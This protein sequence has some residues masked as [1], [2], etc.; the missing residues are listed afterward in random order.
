MFLVKNYFKY[1]LF[2]FLNGGGVIY[3][4]F[5]IIFMGFE[6]YSIR[7]NWL[8]GVYVRNSF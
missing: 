4:I 7:G 1:F 5:M 2:I 3:F 8:V 6:K